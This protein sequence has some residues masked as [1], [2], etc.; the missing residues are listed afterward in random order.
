MTTILILGLFW[1]LY[2]CLGLLGIQVIPDKHRGTEH[3]QAYKRFRGLSWLLLGVPWL[4]V[5]AVMRNVDGPP[6]G[7][8]AMILLVCAMPSLVFSVV[9]ERKYCRL[10]K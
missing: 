1:V 8:M 3:E 4:L 6:T 10:L 9:G 5:W 7:Q 2:G